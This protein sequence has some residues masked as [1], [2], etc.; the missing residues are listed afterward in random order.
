[1]GYFAPHHPRREDTKGDTPCTGTA[2]LGAFVWDPRNV[3]LPWRATQRFH[4]D[5][6]QVLVLSFGEIMA[7]NEDL[8]SFCDLEWVHLAV[9]DCWLVVECL[10]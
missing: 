7:V 6:L 3:W 1:L 5:R 2:K 4:G 8:H 9:L 10:R